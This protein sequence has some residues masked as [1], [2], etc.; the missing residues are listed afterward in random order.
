M[1]NV[2]QFPLSSVDRHAPRAQRRQA[3]KRKER[4][5]FICQ[6]WITPPVA[7]TCKIWEISSPEELVGSAEMT[8]GPVPLPPRAQKPGAARRR[9]EEEGGERETWQG[10]L[11]ASNTH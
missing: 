10:D 6:G 5:R 8:F 2:F 7:R 3:F 4:N 1:T 9:Q 11:V